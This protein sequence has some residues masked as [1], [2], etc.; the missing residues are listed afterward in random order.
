MCGSGKTKAAARR[1][2]RPRREAAVHSGS[3]RAA[4]SRTF[5]L[6][7]L[8]VTRPPEALLPLGGPRKGCLTGSGSSLA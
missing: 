5:L 3:G 6:P 8:P 1:A 2:G 4:E 7:G